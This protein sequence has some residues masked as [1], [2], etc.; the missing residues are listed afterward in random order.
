MADV[1][2]TI[3]AP[4]TPAP[5]DAEAFET[6]YSSLSNAIEQLIGL[7]DAL[8]PDP[9][10]EDSGDSEPSLASLASHGIGGAAMMMTARGRM[11]TWNHPWARLR[12]IPTSGDI[13][14]RARR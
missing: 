7:L 12:T 5:T 4:E 11:R 13:S 9:E 1:S 14:E 2:H 8:D 10:A 6:F 3:D